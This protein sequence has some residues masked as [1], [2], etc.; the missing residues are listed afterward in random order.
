MGI[1]AP[2]GRVSMLVVGPE[3]VPG[4]TVVRLAGAI[5]PAALAM[6]ADGRASLTE[7]GWVVVDVSAVALAPSGVVSEM[8]KRFGERLDF[9]KVRLVCAPAGG[10]QLLRTSGMPLAVFPSI[11]AADFSVSA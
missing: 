9:H 1:S 2:F 3:R 4:G 10:R 8:V 6:L 7:D 5:D 11:A